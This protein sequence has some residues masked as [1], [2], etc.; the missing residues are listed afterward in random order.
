MWN[1]VLTCKPFVI[2]TK[3][4]LFYKWVNQKYTWFGETAKLPNYEQIM[5][6][7]YLLGVEQK[8]LLDPWIC[9]SAVVARITA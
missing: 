5:K 1:Y 2:I 6:R 4:K 9:S 7:Y 8:L 3:K